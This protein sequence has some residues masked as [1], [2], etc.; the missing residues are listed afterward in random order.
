MAACVWHHLTAVAAPV[1]G[2]NLRAARP[3][4]PAEQPALHRLLA[5]GKSESHWGVGLPA[6]ELHAANPGGSER[7][8]P[9][10]LRLST[11][12]AEERKKG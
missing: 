1:L 7:A 5:R 11:S 4:P 12:R 8:D 2:P 6:P 3:A 10:W 9:D